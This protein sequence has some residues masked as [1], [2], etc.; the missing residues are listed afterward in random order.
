[1][2]RLVPYMALVL[3][4]AELVLILVSW[5]LSAALPNSGVR[6]MLSG[7][8]I[9]WFKGKLQNL[10]HFAASFAAFFSAFLAAFSAAMSSL[11]TP[12]WWRWK[13]LSMAQAQRF[14]SRMA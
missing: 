14:I 2:R 5:L 7:E 9:R 11:L 4:L 13:P 12:N 8:G 3:V 10:I 6:S 1:M